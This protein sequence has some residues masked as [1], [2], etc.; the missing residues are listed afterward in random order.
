MHLE[1]RQERFMALIEAHKKLIYKV[2]NTYGKKPEDRHDLVQEIILQIWKSWHT[3]DDRYKLSTWLYRIAL[4]TAI[5]FY[6]KENRR[7]NTVTP[8]SENLINFEAENKDVALEENL[9]LLH[10]FIDQLTALNKALMI[11][12]LDNHSYQEM[13]DILG[14]TE[15][16]VAT[17]V[18]RIKNQLKLKFETY[19]HL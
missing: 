15:T 8:F 19:K 6:R 16:N 4:N 18:S 13:A 10:Q 5:S 7:Q 14:I 17:K 9:K 1:A 12:Y 3:Y 2:S 11:L